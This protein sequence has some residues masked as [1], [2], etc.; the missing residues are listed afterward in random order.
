MTEWNREY[1]MPDR[2]DHTPQQRAHAERLPELDIARAENVMNDG[3]PVVIEDWFDIDCK[4]GVRTTF[5]STLGTDGWSKTDHYS[6]LETNGVLKGKTY[7]GKG[8][9][10][11]TITDGSGNK[12]WSASIVMWEDSA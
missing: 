3:R 4:V 2:S 5:Y 9:G 11:K 7:P 1:L 10:L 12:V 6:Y 8:V